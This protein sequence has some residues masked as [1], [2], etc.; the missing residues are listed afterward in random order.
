MHSEHQLLRTTDFD[1]YAAWILDAEIILFIFWKAGSLV[2][3]HPESLQCVTMQFYGRDYNLC[4]YAVNHSYVHIDNVLHFIARVRL[5][6][7]RLLYIL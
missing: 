2:F 1:E 7:I 4:P 6:V 5:T 3:T